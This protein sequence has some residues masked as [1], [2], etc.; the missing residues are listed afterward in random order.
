MNVPGQGFGF[1]RLS[2]YYRNSSDQ[3]FWHGKICT[4]PT[5]SVRYK[6][7]P[8]QFYYRDVVCV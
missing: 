7:S 3:K 6:I 4:G 2:S 1:I 5:L 8:Y